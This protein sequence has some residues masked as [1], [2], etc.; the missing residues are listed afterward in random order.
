M[1]KTLKSAKALL[2]FFE[3]FEEVIPALKKL[4]KMEQIEKEHESRVTA[5]RGEQ[6]EL[7]AIVL[8]MKDSAKQWEDRSETAKKSVD[9]TTAKSK[10]DADAYAETVKSSAEKN[11]QRVIEEAKATAKGIVADT[12]AAKRE[13]AAV[14]REVQLARGELQTVRGELAKLKGAIPA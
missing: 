11:G 9:E 13:L 2:D 1:S 8:K 3:S 14:K 7:T 6:E 12:E 5:L 10:A 4:G